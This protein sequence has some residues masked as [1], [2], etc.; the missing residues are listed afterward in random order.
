MTQQSTPVRS[1]LESFDAE[2]LRE[3]VKAE[4]RA[5]QRHLPPISVYRWWARRAETVTGAI[6]DAIA[7]ERPGERLLIADN[8]AGGGVIALSALLRGHQVYA[9]D[10]NP[11]AARGLA[12]MLT[13]PDRDGLEGAAERLHQHVEPLLQR[14]YATTLADGTPATLAHTLRVATAPCPGCQTTLRLFPNSLVSLTSRVDCG[15]DT[16]FTVCPAGHLNRGPATKRHGCEECGRYI[17][18][19]ARATQRTGRLGASRAAGS[20]RFQSLRHMAPSAGRQ[21]SSNAAR[22]IAARLTV[23]PTWRRTSLHR[24]TGTPGARV[25]DIADGTEARVL[26]RH[27]MTAWH[28][29]YPARQ[30]VVI[31]AL[32]GACEAAAEGD[33][34]IQ[35]ALEVAIIGTTEMA[36][37][38]SRWDARYL[39]PYEAIANHRFNFTTLSTEPNV[40][41]TPE[42]GRGTLCRRLQMMVKA[43][44]W[45]EEQFGRRLS[46]AGPKP[47][48][49][50]RT[51]VAPTTDAVI[52]VGS[53]SRM[54]LPTG[55]LDA[56]ITDPPYHDDVQYGE[57]SDLFRAWGGSDTGDLDGDAIVRLGDTTATGRTYTKVLTEVFEEIRRAL[58]PDG[59]LV[60]SYANRDPRAWVALFTA[61]QDAGFQVAGYSVVHSENETDH[62]KSGRRSC[63]LD[64]LIDAIPVTDARVVQA[65][66]SALPV[67]DEARFC[68]LV[69]TW[70]LNVGA[71]AP[72]WSEQLT[73]ELRQQSFLS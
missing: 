50:T 5:R 8:F 14:A 19:G 67:T 70:A 25:P 12:T 32:L 24:R 62:S 1:V 46:V 9:Q 52:T 23:P 42:S 27:G 43:S 34:P 2:A 55:S 7:A 21:F 73:C 61:L 38:V 37:H 44:V 57:L 13:L 10:V 66:P 16:G 51:K 31:E 60:L 22:R 58:K 15:G 26:R 28:D 47:S 63:T 36:G 33:E 3:G 4:T 30:R 54:T 11:W 17:K 18:V 72:G 65:T 39:K 71:L 69:G 53:S 64:V 45:L 49:G 48:T 40:W 35:R 56:A 6:V 59:H 41:G 29:L 20:A 68:E